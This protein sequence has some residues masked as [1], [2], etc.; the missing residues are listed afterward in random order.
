[1]TST[2][3][4]PSSEGALSSGAVVAYSVLLDL[5]ALLIVVQG[6]LAGVFLQKDGARDAHSGAIDAHRMVAYVTIV[7]AL[8]S[9]VVAAVRLRS[10][11]DLVVGSAVL[12]VLLIVEA[13][14][15]GRI[16]ESSSDGLTVVHIPLAL[17]LMG[18]ATWLVVRGIALRKN[19]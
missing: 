15:G 18:V 3:A 19:S 12:T 1:M 16:R 5:V 2:T 9:L 10:R 7:L 8:V 4:G 14:L 13:F 17:A 6:V 11:K